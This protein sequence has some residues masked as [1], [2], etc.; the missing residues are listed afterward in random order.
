MSYGHTSYY[1]CYNHLTHTDSDV[2]NICKVF[3]R[4]WLDTNVLSQRGIDKDFHEIYRF[5]TWPS[6]MRYL[7]NLLHFSLLDKNA[8]NN[9][10]SLHAPSQWKMALQCNAISHWLD[11]YTEW[12]LRQ[13]AITLSSGILWTA[14]L[15]YPRT[16]RCL[17]NQ[18]SRRWRLQNLCGGDIIV[19]KTH[20][21][22][23]TIKLYFHV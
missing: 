1:D 17:D 4:W 22:Y 8:D 3:A 15:K 2:S 20:L 18:V 9:D 16:E 6:I 5:R 23:I 12:S 14:Y 21:S 11:A 7:Y 13:Q 19:D 10:H